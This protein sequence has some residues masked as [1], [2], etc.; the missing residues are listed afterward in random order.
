MSV[1]DDILKKLK[2]GRTLVLMHGNADPDAV[3]SAYAIA[4]AFPGTDMHAPEGLDRISKILQ[5][6]YSI[7]LKDNVNLSDYSA[8]VVVDTSSPEQ[9]GPVGGHIA[10]D[11]RLVVI[12]H[13]A[14]T[15]D[16]QAPL[17]FIEQRTSCAEVVWHLFAE[18]GIRS[19]MGRETAELLL[20]GIITDTGHFRFADSG[21]FLAVHGI[22][23]AG[24]ISLQDVMSSI[25]ARTDQS[26]IISVLKGAQRMK[27]ERCCGS[28]VAQSNGSAFEASVSRAILNL[29]ADVV[30]VGSQRKER[31]RIS[32]RANHSL[33]KRGFNLAS[34]LS[35]LGAETLTEGGGHPGAAG[36]S[37]VG[38]AEAMLHMAVEKTKEWLR[39]HKED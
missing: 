29:G 17:S 37:G 31:F 22:M 3:G 2:E 6:R 19:E 5:E 32:A 14:T 20:A 10:G 34:L 28:I 1:P 39:E 30:F 35:E 18:W 24:G 11:E 27:F 13:H 21:T 16:W 7:E 36:V 15:G 23:E 33:I 8:I 26:E 38:D 9:L 12:D 4:A 25:S